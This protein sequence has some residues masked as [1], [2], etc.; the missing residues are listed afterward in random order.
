MEISDCSRAI[1]WYS[2]RQN[3]AVPVLSEGERILYAGGQISLIISVLTPVRQML[4]E[5]P[6]EVRIAEQ[7][8]DIRRISCATAV[9]QLLHKL[10][11]GDAIGIAAPNIVGCCIEAVS[12]GF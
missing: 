10:G 8:G 9:E 6:V 7:I 3:R 12:N 5:I 2:T 1:C 4:L 11:K